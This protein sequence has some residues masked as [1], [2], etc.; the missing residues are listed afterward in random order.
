MLWL[1]AL[2]GTIFVLV[3]LAVYVGDTSEETASMREYEASRAAGAA[4]W[5]D[6]MAR[7]RREEIEV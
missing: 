3:M 5:R 4:M 2:I 6:A 1:A 7:A